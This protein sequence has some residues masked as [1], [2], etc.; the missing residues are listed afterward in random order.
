[1]KLV[2]KTA[3]FVLAMSIA[4]SGICTKAETTQEE[5]KNTSEKIS[6]NAKIIGGISAAGLAVAGLIG[7]GIWCFQNRSL[8]VLIIGGDK[9]TRETLIEK[10]NDPKPM[11]NDPEEN[12][13]LASCIAKKQPGAQTVSKVW[14][15]QE[16]NLKIGK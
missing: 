1:M 2:K 5:N 4:F 13:S 11:N 10:L 16:Q 7:G 6:Q 8:P 9:N 15:K 14:E 3:S 12:D